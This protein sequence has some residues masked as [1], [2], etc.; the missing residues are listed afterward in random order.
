[1]QAV[2]LQCETKAPIEAVF[3]FLGK[4]HNLNRITPPWFGFTILTPEPIVMAE[5]T[6]IDYRIHWRGLRLRWQSLVTEWKPPRLFVYEQAIGPYR[7]FRHD[8]RYES[9]DGSTRVTDRIEFASPGGSWIDRRLLA[10]ELGRILAFRS[11]RIRQLAAEM[12]ST[13]P[14]PSVVA[15]QADRASTSD[16]S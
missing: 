16:D 3:D 9:L 5:G 4:A 8:H 12:A 1:L 6:R 11:R 10:P 15:A 14:S 2:E 7:Y 13:S